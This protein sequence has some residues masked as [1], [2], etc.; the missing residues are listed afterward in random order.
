MRDNIDIF[1]LKMAYLYAERSTCI[2]RKVGAVIVRDKIQL[3]GGYNGAPIGVKHCTEDSCLRIGVKS[4]EN[5]QNCYASHAEGNA[6]A[7]AAKNGVNIDEATMYCTTQPCTYC[8]KLMVNAGIKRLVFCEPYGNGF[9]KLT[10]EI[11]KNVEVVIIS[12]EEVF[13]D[14]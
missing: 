9:D 14:D 12:K 8:A 4:G 2:R 10:H 13:R 11:L 3:S 5:P 1:F 6:I 7:N